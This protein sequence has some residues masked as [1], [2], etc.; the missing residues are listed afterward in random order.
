MLLIF[1]FVCLDES[2]IRLVYKC[3]NLTTKKYMFFVKNNIIPGVRFRFFR[4]SVFLIFILL[5]L[6]LF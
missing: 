3:I 4:R 6:Y 5:F 2:Y 1:V